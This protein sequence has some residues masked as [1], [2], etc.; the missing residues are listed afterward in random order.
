MGGDIFF[1]WCLRNA[2]GWAAFML[3]G[4]KLRLDF[5]GHKRAGGGWGG[6]GLLLT[7]D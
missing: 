2:T 1:W 3:Q 7:I 5:R 6:G 4:D